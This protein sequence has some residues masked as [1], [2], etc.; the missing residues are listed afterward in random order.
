MPRVF[1]TGD[2]RD[3][4]VGRMVFDLSLRPTNQQKVKPSRTV[5]LGEASANFGRQKCLSVRVMIVAI[6]VRTRHSPLSPDAGDH[7]AEKCRMS[8]VVSVR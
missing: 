7:C 4:C 5:S 3:T 6:G 1:Q 2:T 8:S